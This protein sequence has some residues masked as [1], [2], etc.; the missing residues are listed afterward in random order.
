MNNKTL[1]PVGVVVFAISLAIL[2]R[3]SLSG[4][5]R[6]IAAGMAVGLI[7]GVPIGM[8]SMALAERARRA[9]RVAPPQSALSLSEQQTDRLARAIE[10]RQAAPESFGLAARPDRTFEAIGGA[11][12]PTE[13]GDDD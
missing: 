10:P 8:L 2:M 13:P 6:L 3:D 1:I 4:E 11:D 5:T 7:V 12:L 9:G